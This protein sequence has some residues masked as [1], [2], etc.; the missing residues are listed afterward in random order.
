[1]NKKLV[2]AINDQIKYEFF[3][4]FLYLAMASY[5]S[6]L[7]LTGFESWLKNQAAEEQFHA[8]KFIDYLHER[9]ERALVLGF[10]DPKNEYTSILEAF[11]DGLAHEKI[12][13]SRINNLMKIA[14]EDNDYASANFLN[15]YVTEQVEEEASFTTVINKLKMVGSSPMGLYQLDK[16]LGGRQGAAPST[17]AG[18]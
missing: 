11:E 7:E 16:E 15:W 1:M 9:N 12:V 5:A 10:E 2:D 18:Q 14:L 13:T 8:T 17:G 3:S 6:D 4:A